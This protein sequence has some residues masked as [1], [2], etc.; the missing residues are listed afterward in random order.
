MKISIVGAY[1]NGRNDSI[2]LSYALTKEGGT[3]NE[4]LPLD[5]SDKDDGGGRGESNYQPSTQEDMLKKLVSKDD[6]KYD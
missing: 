5:G 1:L 4:C 3:P 6:A 2:H